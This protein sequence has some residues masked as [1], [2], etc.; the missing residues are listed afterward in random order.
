M[1]DS[2]LQRTAQGNNQSKKDQRKP[3]GKKDGDKK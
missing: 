3:E 1:F 2:L